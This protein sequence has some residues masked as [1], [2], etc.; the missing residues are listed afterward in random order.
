MLV[1]V[2]SLKGSPGV[3]TLCVALAARWPAPV[4]PLVV[5]ADPSGGDLAMRFNL[6]PSPGLLS[7]TAAARHPGEAGAGADPGLV[8]RH[9]QGLPGDLPV[10]AA[11][12]DAPRARSAVSSLAA[13][14]HLNGPGPVRSAASRPEAVVVVDV[15]RLDTDSAA[16][17]LVRA[18]DVMVVLTRSGADDL[19]HLARRIPEIGSW[20]RSPV[21]LLAGRGHSAAAVT[22]EL[23]VTPLGRVPDDPRGAAVLRGQRGVVRWHHSGPGRS[24]L[25]QAAA[26]IASMLSETV[27]RRSLPS[28]AV[29]TPAQ[30]I[31]AQAEPGVR[32]GAARPLVGSADGPLGSGPARPSGNGAMS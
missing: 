30:G 27:A 25:G 6:T 5:E 11:P 8:W 14:D 20:S 31:A 32:A 24:L 18:A 15:G 22:R 7:L 1:A 29:S 21:L 16:M 13:S 2:A 10:V 28:A 23:G 26:D 19:A 12:P 17:P 3:T 4:H 9:A